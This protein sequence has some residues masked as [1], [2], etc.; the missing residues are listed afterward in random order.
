MKIGI[1]TVPDSANFGSFLQGLA[2]QSVLEKMGHEV[3]FVST[4]D[5][6]YIRR[7]Y[8]NWKPRK[9][10]VL[11]PIRYIMGN[12]NGY[13]KYK[14]FKEDQ[15]RMKICPLASL[16]KIDL[17]IL[18]SDE[19]WNVNTPVFRHSIF[20]G[21]GMKPVFAYAVSI[22]QASHKEIEKFPEIVKQICNINDIF[23]RDTK[24]QNSIKKITGRTPELVCDPTF[25]V[26]KNL[27]FKQS[28]NLYTNI[29]RYILVYMYPHFSLK[30]DI[31][32]IRTFAKKRRLKLIS[33]GFYNRWCDHNIVCGP[34]DFCTVISNSE[35]VVT[36]TF[37][38]S[39]FS[40]LNG[41]QFVSI[42]TSEKVKDLLK[43][44]DLEQYLV[45]PECVTEEKLEKCLINNQIDY[46]KVNKE[47]EIWKKYSMEKLRE[48]IENNAKRN[49]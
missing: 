47:I 9:R 45:E 8:Y 18:G 28:S 39:I 20:Y 41:K 24:T 17:F 35:Y 15:K 36:A 32:A 23:V 25:L 7:I 38:G 14:M 49:M 30:E 4:R 43:R 40:I 3:V 46:V 13:K 31:K 1:V 33:V 10:D 44:L 29:N 37:H 19:I 2:L 5:K 12:I 26:D 16:K 6:E 48:G 34:L 42:A 11:H 27:L 22:G 21:A